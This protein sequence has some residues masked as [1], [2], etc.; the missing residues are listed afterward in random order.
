MTVVMAARNASATIGASI[1][2]IR[3]QTL[4]DWELIVIDDGSTDRTAAVVADHAKA[5]AR[6]RLIEGPAAGVANARNLGLNEA[7]GRFVA[8]LDSDDLAFDDRLARQV[9]FIEANEAWGCSSQAVLFVEDRVALG[10]SSAGGPRTREEL[11]AV[12]AQGTLLVATH[13]TFMFRA[14]SIAV[15]GGYDERFAVAED[16]EFLNR[17]VHGHGLVYLVLDEPLCWYRI[18]SGGLSTGDGLRRERR[19]AAYVEQRNLAWRAGRAEP[20]FAA[21][22]DQ[23]VHPITAM[24][25]RRHDLGAALYRRGGFK[26]GSKRWVSGLGSV[27]AAGI[28]HPRYVVSKLRA[29]RKDFASISAI[30]SKADLR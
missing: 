22:M 30:A 8:V 26:I 13:P 23:S 21:F 14:D 3:A 9:A 17:A 1:Q 20:E 4:T 6:I 27:L 10:R 24:R 16:V 2:S 12:R 19:L 5:D 28:L 18:T 25:W 29:Q 15:L 7:R 11:E